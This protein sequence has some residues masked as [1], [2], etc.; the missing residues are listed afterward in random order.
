M[1]VTVIAAGFDRDRRGSFT[2]QPGTASP[3]GRASFLDDASDIRDGE[4]GEGTD[5]MDIPG[6][7]QG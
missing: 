5:E 7:V 6:F 2:A 1:R 4:R 3:R